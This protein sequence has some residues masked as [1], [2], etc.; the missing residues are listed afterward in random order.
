MPARSHPDLLVLRALLREQAN[1]GAAYPRGP[2]SSGTAAANQIATPVAPWTSQSRAGAL[3]RRHG[4]A[5]RPTRTTNEVIAMTATRRPRRPSPGWAM[6]AL[7]RAIRILRYVNETLVLVLQ[8][9]F[10]PADVRRPR[11]ASDALAEKHAH[12]AP[13]LE[14]AR[15]GSGGPGAGLGGARSRRP[16][17]GGHRRGRGPCGSRAVACPVR[18][19]PAASRAGRPRRRQLRGPASL[20]DPDRPIRKGSLGE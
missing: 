4:L 3:S 17:A 11:P 13:V 6:N 19:R 14:Y 15:P 12:L 10:P 1:P 2:N 18:P 9:L 8:A 20:Q 16:Q 5:P 7:R